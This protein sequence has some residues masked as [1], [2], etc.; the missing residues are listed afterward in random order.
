MAAEASI[1]ES[2]VTKAYP[3]LLPFFCTIIFTPKK[4]T[5]P[6]IHT[7]K[8]YKNTVYR[9]ERGET[10]KKINLNIFDGSTLSEEIPDVRSLE[11]PRQVRNV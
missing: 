11:G 4:N 10:E 7:Q 9:I 5:N 1:T 8:T 2:M 3:L 6:I